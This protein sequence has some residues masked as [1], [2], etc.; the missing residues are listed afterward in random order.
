M[1]PG[2]CGLAGFV[3]ATG[4][5]DCTPAYDSG[6]R[7]S[8]ITISTT[9]SVTGSPSLLL[10]GSVSGTGFYFTTQT[11]AGKTLKFDFGAP[12]KLTEATALQSTATTQ[13]VWQWQ[14]SLDDSTWV[15]VGS[16]FTWSAATTVV[17]T[18][19]AGNEVGARYWR[20]LGVS[21]SSS[22]GPWQYEINFKRCTC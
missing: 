10:D 19:L 13:G 14:Y 5:C 20:L 1:I 8:E 6:D 7:T 12:V 3:T 4:G 9:L 11:V 15:D 18:Q 2:L 17:M 21:G 16:S 22:S